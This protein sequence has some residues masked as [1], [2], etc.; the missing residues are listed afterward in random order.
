MKYKYRINTNY[1]SCSYPGIQCKFYY[2]PNKEQQNGQ[3]PKHLEDNNYYEVSFMIF[4]TGS[5]LIVGKCNENIL[6]VIYRFIKTILETEFSGIQMGL[7]V[8]HKDLLVDGGEGGE[9][10]GGGQ[11][12]ESDDG[13]D[14]I[15]SALPVTAKCL[16]KS[17]IKPIRKKKIYVTNV[18]YYVENAEDS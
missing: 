16:G 10:G 12:G 5:I 6:H 1:D 2:I 9:G 17:T 4:R 3:Q 13:S 7:V 11:G 14:K 18:K 8:N 15:T